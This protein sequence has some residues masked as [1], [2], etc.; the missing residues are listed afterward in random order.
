MVRGPKCLGHK[1]QLSK[2]AN[3]DMMSIPK[4]NYEAYLKKKNHLVST[5]VFTNQE[6]QILLYSSTPTSTTS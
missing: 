6:D 4:D 2:V 3:N 5:A 1:L